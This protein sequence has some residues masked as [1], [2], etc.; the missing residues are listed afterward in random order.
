[1]PIPQHA[2]L[3]L[4]FLWVD[5]SGVYHYHRQK[6]HRYFPHHRKT[7]R[8]R[9]TA[10]LA[11]SKAFHSTRFM[12][13]S[14]CSSLL[15]D[16]TGLYNASAAFLHRIIL[17]RIFQR[18]IYRKAYTSCFYLVQNKII[19]VLLIIVYH[20]YSF[21]P[22]LLNEICFITR[23]PQLQQYLTSSRNVS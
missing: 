22:S 15:S 17:R 8:T 19:L 6:D 1:M 21:V 16:V 9:F 2:T 18:S 5:S 4:P 11:D 23:C 10:P 13:I 20:S 3:P 14:L 7:R 12:T